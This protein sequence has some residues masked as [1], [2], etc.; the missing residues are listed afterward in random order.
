MTGADYLNIEPGAKN[1]QRNGLSLLVDVDSFE[2]GDYP[3]VDTV[4]IIDTRY[5]TAEST[6]Y[7]QAITPGISGFHPGS[8]QQR[9]EADGA[10]RW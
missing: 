5:L 2:Y 1:G 9:G 10:A 8:V 4:M 3:K 7:L 6:R